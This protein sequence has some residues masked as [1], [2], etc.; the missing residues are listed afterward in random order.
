MGT[1]EGTVG[2]LM[3]SAGYLVSLPD[4]QGFGVS[5]ALH[6]Y[7]HAE[8]LS[9]AV[10]DLLVAAEEAASRVGAS[11]DERLFLTGYSEGGYATLAAHKEIEE[12]YPDRFQLVAS[13]PMAGPYD[14]SGTAR[15]LFQRQTYEWPGY[16]AFLL[17]AYDDIY[18]WDRLAEM[19]EPPYAEMM[20]GLFDGT[21]D[22]DAVNSQLPV[23]LSELLQD[24]F[25]QGFLD[26]SETEVIR[27]IEENDL[28][29]WTPVAPIRFYHGDADE[30]VPY[31][32][33]V[34]AVERLS[35]ATSSV[36]LVTIEGG[37]HE[38]A[39]LPA[40]LDMIRWFNQQ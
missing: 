37:T 24:G 3:A 25:V 16:I 32:N 4:Y 35:S 15:G 26:G 28:L 33:S 36:E 19:F 13:A 9:A 7:V 18:G 14:L 2:M 5:G 38:T 39:G 23:T 17:T 21:R 30:A 8:S 22:F 31:Q 12:S 27:A 1:V 20:P 10:V 6:P 34:T 40:L 29:D 11:P